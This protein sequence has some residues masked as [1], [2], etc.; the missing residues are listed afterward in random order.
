MCC[1][2]CNP[3]NKCF[4]AVTTT[5]NDSPPPKMA[6]KKANFGPESVFLWVRVVISCLISPNF[7]VV[8]S[9]KMCCMSLKALT[10]HVI[11]VVCRAMCCQASVLALV[12]DFALLHVV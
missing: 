3:V 4:R 8:D 9:N 6:Q 1:T 7:S 2:T 12:H 10:S 11:Y 5:K